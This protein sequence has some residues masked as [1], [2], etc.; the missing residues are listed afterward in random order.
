MRQLARE[1]VRLAGERALE[2]ARHVMCGWGRHEE[3]VE[4]HLE[5][6]RVEL[7]PRCELLVQGRIFGNTPRRHASEVVPEDVLDEVE[8][9]CGSVRGG[10]GV[11]GSVCAHRQSGTWCAKGEQRAA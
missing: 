8:D 5:R 7:E 11:I 1:G 10:C 4:E 2:P 3:A 6:L 9:A